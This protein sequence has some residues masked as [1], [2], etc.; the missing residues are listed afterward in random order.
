[1]QTPTVPVI[2]GTVDAIWSTAYTTAITN[3]SA[4]SISGPSDC[5]GT[6]QTLWD[7]NNLYVLVQVTDDIAVHDT[8]VPLGYEDDA[9][10]L[11]VDANNTKTTNYLTNDFHYG[12][13]IEGGSNIVVE[14]AHNATTGVVSKYLTN[15][16]NANYVVEV[17]IPWSTLGQSPVAADARLGF[18][19]Q[20]D[21]N[22]VAGGHARS[23]E[24]QWHDNG[25]NDY[26]DPSHFGTARLAPLP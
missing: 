23:A 24:L 9:V 2:D 16:L 5:S 21:D 18:D 13:Y 19:A 7:T 4:G 14:L 17:K 12:F 3:V 22:D 20:I 11:Y 10:E 6:Y 1:V 8:G 15:S 26:H 25:D